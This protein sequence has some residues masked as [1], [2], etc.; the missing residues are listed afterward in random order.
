M[1]AGDWALRV[2]CVLIAAACLL[3]WA[4]DLRSHPTPARWWVRLTFPVGI[5]LAFSALF[6]FFFWA[7]FLGLIVAVIGANLTDMARVGGPRWLERRFARLLRRPS[8]T[9]R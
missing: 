2:G 8:A 6:T 7:P 9:D 4:W 1:T 3:G 5:V